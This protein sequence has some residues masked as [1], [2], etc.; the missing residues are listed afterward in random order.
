MAADVDEE[1][2]EASAFAVSII[3]FPAS[4]LAATVGCCARLLCAA[5]AVVAAAD[6]SKVP[7]LASEAPDAAVFGCAAPEALSSVVFG[8]TGTV[9]ATAAVNAASVAVVAL[10]CVPCCLAGV[11]TA[12][13]AAA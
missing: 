5:P 4:C 11:A 12:P 13:L 7:E 2:A 10:V 8:A 3:P 1:P 9:A 6:G